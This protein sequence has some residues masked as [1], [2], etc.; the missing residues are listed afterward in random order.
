M[1]GILSRE[2]YFWHLL[3]TRAITMI[4]RHIYYSSLRI[5]VAL[6]NQL[7]GRMT[8]CHLRMADLYDL[9][10]SGNSK[11]PSRNC[12]AVKP[13]YN[14]AS[15]AISNPGTCKVQKYTPVTGVLVIN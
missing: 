7:N 10:K 1:E 13:L 4:I 15:A 11:H 2:K 6:A 8:V 14:H 3:G 5:A 9:F 12:P